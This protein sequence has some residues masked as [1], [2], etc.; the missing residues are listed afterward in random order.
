[1]KAT[2]VY[3]YVKKIVYLLNEKPPKLYF[4]VTILLKIFVLV[5][6]KFI[7]FSNR[8][9]I[10]KYTAFLNKMSTTDGSNGTGGGGAPGPG[11]GNG[12]GPGGGSNATTGGKL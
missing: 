6:I 5:N 8:I 11:G 9:F 4:S 1:M 10:N 3:I 2:Y 12:A 7:C